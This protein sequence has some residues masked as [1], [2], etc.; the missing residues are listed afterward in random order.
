MQRMTCAH[1]LG[2]ILLHKD[3]LAGNVPLL[4]Y[5]LFDIRNSTEYEANVF[6]ADLLIDEAE[7]NEL[8]MEGGDVVSIASAL[9]INVNLLLIKLIEMRRDGKELQVPFTPERGFLGKIDDFDAQ[10]ERF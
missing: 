3:I 6:A 1:E 7:L 10:I 4:E 9:D 8:V 5:E 2:H